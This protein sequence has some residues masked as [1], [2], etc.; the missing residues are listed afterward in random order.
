VPCRPV[1]S[2][3]PMDD[4]AIPRL[5]K[6]ID[7]TRI[8]PA[9]MARCREALRLRYRG[10]TDQALELGRTMVRMAAQARC[11]DKRDFAAETRRRTSTGIVLLYLAYIRYL[12]GS[13]RAQLTGQLAV[14]WLNYDEHHRLIAELVLARLASEESR[15]NDAVQHYHAALAILSRLIAVQ[16][17]KNNLLKEKEYVQLQQATQQTIKDACLHAR[18]TVVSAGLLAE[19]TPD[20][21]WLERVQLPCALV[22]PGDDPIGLQ[23]M[24]L[25]NAGEQ[26]AILSPNFRP[27]PGMLDYIEVDQVSFNNQSYQIEVTQETGGK[28]RMYTSQPYYVF[29]FEATSRPP[30]VGEP[31]YA[32]VR[33]FDRP[34]PPDW[35]IVILISAEQRAWLV[36]SQPPDSPAIIGG[37]KWSIQDGTEIKSYNRDDVQIA[38]AVVAILTPL[39]AQPVRASS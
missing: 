20:L 12:S 24:P 16:R 4:L 18:R 3:L 1:S 33:Q 8:D 29:Q 35:P 34:L 27:I 21:G 19:E 10:K 6:M 9:I 7:T 28:F 31:C 25:Q 39:P 32:L 11:V 2:E 30:Q 15:A 14:T 26:Q 5:L 38:G 13:P 17:R 36:L 22:W 37:R 23:L